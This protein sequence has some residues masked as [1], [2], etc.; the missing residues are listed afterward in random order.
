MITNILMEP[1]Q[2][3]YRK[4]HSP[5]TTLRHIHNDIV[6]AVDN[7]Q[8]VCLILLDLSAAFDTVEHKMFLTFLREYVGLDRSSINL[9]ES[10]LRG[11]GW[12]QCVSVVGVLSELN[13]LVYGIP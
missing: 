6:S 3:T 2:S 7:R 11:G 8:G 9:F 10:L 4:V 1:M 12:I 13:E 5:K